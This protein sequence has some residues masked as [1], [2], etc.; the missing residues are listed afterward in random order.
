MWKECFAKDQTDAKTL[1]C[2]APETGGCYSAH[3][4][5]GCNERGTKPEG[6]AVELADCIIRILDWFGRV[7]MKPDGILLNVHELH[8]DEPEQD[9]PFGDFISM[10]HNF[11]SAAAYDSHDDYD[12]AIFLCSVVYFI[13]DSMEREGVDLLPIIREKMDYNKTRP[14]RHGGKRL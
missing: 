13:L 3:I 2:G 5:K 4:G 10:M 6:I 9:G 1:W 12:R 8:K 7:D 11:L 14:Y